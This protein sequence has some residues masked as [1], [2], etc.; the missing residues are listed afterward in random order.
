MRLFLLLALLVATGCAS[1][2]SSLQTAKPLAPGQFQVSG[3]MGV[4][5]PA[6]Q[7][8]VLAEQGIRQG[9]AIYDAVQAEQP[10]ALS[11]ADAVTLLTAGAALAVAPPGTNNELMVRGGLVDNVDLGLRLTTNSVR[12]DGK[13]RLAHSGTASP[14]LREHER[15]SLDLAIGL[16]V[17][18]HLF[19]SPVLD[20]LQVVKIDDFS[21]YDVEVPL[22]LSLDLGDIFKAYAVPKYVFSHT[23]MDE[24]LVDF[25][26]EGKDVTGF[27]VVLPARVNSHFA[28]ATLGVALGY[29]YVHVYAELTAGYTHSRPLF[30]GQERDLGGVTLYPAIGIA[31]K[32]LAPELSQGVM[33]AGE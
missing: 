20:A 5:V 8:T 13:W 6:G 3:G 32:N 19:K 7:L 29:K 22:Y 31:I 1:S 27:D 16:G 30:F 2:L 25:S 24:K 11:E 15:T 4:F 9:R 12:L 28:G 17:S 14:A 33:E 10:Y 18:R 21:R 23:R 26:Q